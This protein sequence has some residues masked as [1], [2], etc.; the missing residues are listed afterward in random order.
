MP[1]DDYARARA[2]QIG[3]REAARLDYLKSRKQRSKARKAASTEKLATVNPSRAKKKHRQWKEQVANSWQDYQKRNKILHKLGYNSYADYL[4]SDRW[5]RI[6]KTVLEKYD[7]RCR[8]CE[9][10]ANEVHHVLYT[11]GNL[12]GGNTNHLIPLC[13]KCHQKLEFELGEKNTPLE[14]QDKLSAKL[15]NKQY[16]EAILQFGKHKGKKLIQVPTAYLK[17]LVDVPEPSSQIKHVLHDVKK[18]L[19]DRDNQQSK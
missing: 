10:P 7:G 11:K 19:L 4:R 12:S 16:R 13:R 14:A 2:K 9:S 6:R 5:K 3:Q 15:R 18:V 17:W 1:R 8:I